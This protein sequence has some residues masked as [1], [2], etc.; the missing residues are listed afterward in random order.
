MVFRPTE[1]KE[2]ALGTKLLLKA[3]R[4]ASPKCAM[5]RR[6]FN[7]GIHGNKKGGRRKEPS[8]FGKQLQEK[9]KVQLSYGLNNNQMRRLFRGNNQA[10]EVLELLEK[11]LDNVIF[12]LGL[13]DSRVIARQLINHGHFFVNDRKMAIPSY[14]VRIGDKI[15]LNADSRKLKIFDGLEAKLKKSETLNWLKLDKEKL[16]GELIGKPQEINLPFDLNLVAEY[17]SR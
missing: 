6:P 1:K 11:R 4:C 2:R 7:P 17:Y 8:A 16:I 5:I 12:R 15:S 14:L 3:F 13:A 10:T 9:Q